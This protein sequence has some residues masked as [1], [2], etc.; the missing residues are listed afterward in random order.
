MGRPKSFKKKEKWDKL[1]TEFKDAVQQMSTD[2]IRRRVS[3]TALLE[4]NYRDLLK[5]DADV[6]MAREKLKD[7]TGPYNDDIKACRL[8]IEFCQKTLNEKGVGSTVEPKPLAIK[9]V[10]VGGTTFELSK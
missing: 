9:S 2:E 7:L 1:E 6:I 4:S 5:K 8:K 3:D 10:T